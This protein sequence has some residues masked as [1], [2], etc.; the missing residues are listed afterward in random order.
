[1]N[2]DLPLALAQVAPGLRIL[3]DRQAPLL[4]LPRSSRTSPMRSLR[5]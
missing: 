3:H 4:E 5:A 2:H 1:M